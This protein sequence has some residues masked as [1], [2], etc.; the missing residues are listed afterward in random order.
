M[1]ARAAPLPSTVCF[2]ATQ[3]THSVDKQPLLTLPQC[4]IAKHD[5]KRRHLHRLTRFK[6]NELR[7]LEQKMRDYLEHSRAMHFVLKALSVLGV[8]LILADTILTPAQS[9]LGAVQGA[10]SLLS[11]LF[12][13]ANQPL[14]LRVVRP[15]LGTDLIV[16]VSCAI[17]VLLFL[18]QPLGISRLAKGFA[19]IVVVW[20]LLNFC[21]GIYVSLELSC[22]LSSRANARKESHHVR[23]HCPQGL[24]TLLCL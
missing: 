4:D 24:F 16:G 3:V 6:S 19:P 2:R 11:S 10:T 23:S 15:D 13:A 21:F 14:G 20:L 18:L 17:I 12:A 1:R 7:P 9:V 8:S 22:P 5:P